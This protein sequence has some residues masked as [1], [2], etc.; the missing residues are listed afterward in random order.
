[1]M[2]F[3]RLKED[4]QSLH[5]LITCRIV[6]ETFPVIKSVLIRGVAFGGRS[7]IRGVAFDGRSLIRGGL[8]NAL[9]E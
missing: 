1:M 5:Q 7:L 3:A 2:I 9:R 8:P 4:K 6:N